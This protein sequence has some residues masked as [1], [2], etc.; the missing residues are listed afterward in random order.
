MPAEKEFIVF[1]DSLDYGMLGSTGEAVH[2]KY[3]PD[4]TNLT[5]AGNKYLNRDLYLNGLKLTSGFNYI[6]NSSNEIE[7]IRSTLPDIQDAQISFVARP[8]IANAITGSD[9][10]N[11]KNVGFG[12]LSEQIWI[13]GLRQVEGVNYIKTPK[14][15]LLNTPTI[16]RSHDSNIYSD[17]EDFFNQ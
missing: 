3:I 12:L 9:M 8:I 16:L 11:H 7:I 13:N 1:D 5:L 10:G 6:E 15:S 14:N 17:T 4:S 2:I